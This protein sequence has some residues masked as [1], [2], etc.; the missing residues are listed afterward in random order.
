MRGVFV[1][2]ARALRSA[3]AGL[4][5]LMAAGCLPSE[6]LSGPPRSGDALPQ[7]AA[8]DLVGDTVSLQAYRGEGVLLNLWATW[9]P[10]CRAEMPY[11][12]ELADEYGPRGL[13]VVGLSVDDR[14]ARDQVL[15]FLEESGVRYDVLLDPAMTSMDQLGVLGLPATFLVDPDGVIQHVLTGPIPEGNEAFLARLEGVLPERAGEGA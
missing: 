7:M 11:L 8:V 13:R 10:P 9:C 2:T 14:G 1:G 6:G 15:A 3:V 4:A 5:L 12:Q